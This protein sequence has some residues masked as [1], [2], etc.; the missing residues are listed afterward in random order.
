MADSTAQEKSKFLKEQQN[1]APANLVI[2]TEDISDDVP[3]F[4]ELSD[5]NNVETQPIVLKTQSFAQPRPTVAQTP[6]TVIQPQPTKSTMKKPQPKVKQARPKVKSPTMKQP[7]T[8]KKKTPKGKQVNVVAGAKSPSILEK[9]RK[10]SHKETENQVNNQQVQHKS[11]VLV[12]SRKSSISS[13]SNL[14]WTKDISSSSTSTCIT[15]S[16]NDF[17]RFNKK[18]PILKLTNIDQEVNKRKN[19]K[20]ATVIDE[21]DDSSETSDSS[22]SSDSQHKCSE[23]LNNSIEVNSLHLSASSPSSSHSSQIC[24]K[25]NSLD[26]TKAAKKLTITMKKIDMEI[27]NW[28]SSENTD[29]NANLAKFKNKMFEV[30]DHEFG[31][32]THCRR[33]K[34]ILDPR[35]I[36][37]TIE[38]PCIP[39][40]V[41]NNAVNNN[42]EINPNCEKDNPTLDNNNKI[43]IHKEGEIIK[44]VDTNKEVESTKEIETNKETETNKKLETNKEVE[45]VKPKPCRKLSNISEGN[46]SITSNNSNRDDYTDDDNPTGNTRNYIYSDHHDDDDALSLFAESITGFESSRMTNSI[47]SAPNVRQVEEYIPQPLKDNYVPHIEKP[48]Y[49]PTKIREEAE[50]F[51]SKIKTICEKQNADS[52]SIY[53]QSNSTDDAES[54][55]DFNENTELDTKM[56]APEMITRPQLMDSLFQI[57]PKT[58][59][60]VFGGLCFYNLMNCCRK[61][62]LGQ[63]RFRHLKPQTDEIKAKLNLL[64]DRVLI[65]EYLLLRNWAYLRR[66]YGM[67]YVEE[68]AKRGL[69][70]ILVEIAYD[71]IVKARNMEGD[72]RL[73]VNTIEVTL[74]HLNNV[75]LSVCEDLL[76]LTIHSDQ[77]NKTLLCDVFMAT[78]SITQNFSRFK[79]VFLNLT[80][81]MVD[82]DRVFNMDVVKHILERICILPFEEPIARALI[83]MMRLTRPEIFKNSMI[84]HFEKQIA[85]N[86]DVFEE[87][88]LLKNRY[89]FTSMLA[90]SVVRSSSPPPPPSEPRDEGQPA[91]SPDTTNLD[92]MVSSLTCFIYINNTNKN[93]CLFVCTFKIYFDK[94]FD[95]LLALLVIW[96]DD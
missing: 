85:V 35:V 89:E 9:L 40:P 46:V 68:C 86:K 26:Y 41:E 33:L 14:S 17:V 8:P 47:A 55:Q 83:Q 38:N 21:D 59:S 1:I 56:G 58:K 13:N 12:D 50:M 88:S 24:S 20:E 22:D 52:T 39:N 81:F 28:I 5:I 94:T 49:C 30:L 73:R 18:L 51:A 44:E 80:Y 43:Q 69:T 37:E 65:Q 7:A 48:T 67:C 11:A 36:E 78:M 72:T 25:D 32:I 79:Q 82:N 2:K 4:L 87:Y 76:K 60:I 75:D 91:P 29:V 92:N 19:V 70:R 6:P 10:L 54:Y 74:L 77:I 95:I 3:V 34:E 57:L 90:S 64:D 96:V 23:Q 31:L 53:K 42:T 63:C 93:S 27:I 84:G 66:Q 16:S 45:F 71:F 62:A 61:M 15:V